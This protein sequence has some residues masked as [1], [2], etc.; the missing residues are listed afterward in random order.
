MGLQGKK[1][2]V[3]GLGVTGKALVRLLLRLGATPVAADEAKEPELVR[4]IKDFLSSVSV[5][6]FFGEIEPEVF[7]GCELILISPGIRRDHPVIKYWQEREVE[8]IGEIELGYRLCRAPIIAV[9]GSNG[10]TT[11]TALIAHILK[12]FRKTHLVGNIG[13][14]FADIADSAKE[15]EVVCL[16]VSSFQL[17]TCTTFAPKV[18]VITNITPDH[19][20]RYESFESYA[21]TKRGIAKNLKTGSY[22]VYNAEDE[23]LEPDLFP[24]GGFQY[25]PFSSAGEVGPPGAFVE[26]GKLLI[27]GIGRD[28][29][30]PQSILKIPGI[31]NVENALAGAVAARIFGANKAHLMK[32]LRSF[33]GYEHR[34]EFVREIR[35]VK[36]YNDSKATNP[37]ASIVAMKTFSGPII[38]IAGGRDKG[39]NLDTWASVVKSR[40]KEVILIG[41]A[42]GKLEKALRENQFENIRYANGIAEAVKL[43]YEISQSGDTVLFSPACASFD[44]FKNFEERGNRFKEEVN[45]L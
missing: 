45:S 41:E 27:R 13:S 24:Q 3:F 5:K 42:R 7:N 22:L 6:G 36:F 29:E 38:L 10:K 25:V 8:I 1:V 15:D 40:C 20:D 9:T 33:R 18:A 14:A 26:S 31:H 16:E 35:K 4:E 30:L 12:S 37:E 44:M 19:L 32:G 2:G 43:A 17:E 39:T 28:V 21:E 23:N 34:L 11:T